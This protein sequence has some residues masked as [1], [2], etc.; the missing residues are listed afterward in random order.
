M[1]F[2]GFDKESLEDGR[3]D[4]FFFFITSARVQRK[5]S[6]FIDY[7]HPKHAN[8]SKMENGKGHMLLL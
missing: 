7:H 1:N 4:F 3:E 5:I 8:N 2:C 6:R